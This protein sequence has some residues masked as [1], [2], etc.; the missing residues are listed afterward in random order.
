MSYSDTVYPSNGFTGELPGGINYLD[1]WY[2]FMQM[3]SMV[4]VV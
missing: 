4:L 1:N 2:F 3:H